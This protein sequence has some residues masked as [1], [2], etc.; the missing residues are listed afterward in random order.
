MSNLMA[1]SRK[2]DNPYM[3]FQLGEWE[4]RVLKSYQKDNGKPYARAFCAVRSPYTFGSWEYGDT[5]WADIP[6]YAVR[7]QC[8][9]SVI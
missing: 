4:W 8:D 5:Y 9:P 3:T 2:I 1:K 7:V 6:K